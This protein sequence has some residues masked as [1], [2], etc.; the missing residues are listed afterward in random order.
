MA[1]KLAARHSK[2]LAGPPGLEPSWVR[3]GKEPPRSWSVRRSSAGG[4]T[5]KRVR[6]TSAATPGNR[7]NDIGCCL[8][9]LPSGAG[10]ADPGSAGPHVHRGIQK[11][12]END[13]FLSSENNIT[14]GKINI[15]S[16]C[17][18]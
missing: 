1:S 10:S 18:M 7:G 9:Q 8:W 17:I 2:L 15:S 4:P 3:K 5:L 13:I 16:A 11:R 12:V 14:D 6:W